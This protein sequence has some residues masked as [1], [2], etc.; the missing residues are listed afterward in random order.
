MVPTNADAA[1]L[2]ALAK[3]MIRVKSAIEGKQS[4]KWLCSRTFSKSLQLME[5]ERIVR[6]IY[7]DNAAT[8]KIYDDALTSFIQ[9]SQKFFGNHRAYTN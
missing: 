4:A 8:T 6:M 1:A 2:E 3:S 5:F 7:F 9:V